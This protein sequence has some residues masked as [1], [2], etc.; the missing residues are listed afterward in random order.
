MQYTIKNT[1]LSLTVDSLGAQMISLKNETGE[2]LLWQADKN[3][4]GYS[5]PMLFPWVGRIKDNKFIAN[6]EEYPAFNHGFIR[7]VEHSLVIKEDNLIIFEYKA[8]AESRKKFPYNFVFRTSYILSGHSV[9]HK[10]DI[11]NTDNCDLGFGLG[12]HPGY[13]LPF[14]DKHTTEDYYIEFDTPQSPNVMSFSDRFLLDGSSYVYGENISK[15]PLKDN[16]FEKDSLIFSG[17]TAKTVSIVEKDSGK[18]IDLDIQDFPYVV[19]WT[20]ATPKT[21][22]F[23]VEPCLSLPDREDAPLQWDKKK[24]SITLKPGEAY[25]ILSR[26]RFTR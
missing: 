13:N 11:T 8:C 1:H 4:W 17:L 21:Q 22:F 16:F 25:H 10:V 24:H 26:V 7:N 5:A 9:H 2:E 20:A 3:V 19:L 6:G 12:F 23:C 18:R 14:D 15:I